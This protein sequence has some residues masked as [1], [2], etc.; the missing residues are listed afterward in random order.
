SELHAIESV[1]S[2]LE[3]NAMKIASRYIVVDD[4]RTHYLEAG[5]GPPVVLL[6][7]GEF[8]GAAELSWEFTIPALAAHYR[9][10]APDWLGFGRTDK[11]HDFTQGQARRL[12]H[13]RRF[14]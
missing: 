2:E 6:H 9:V 7:S 5:E 14:I 13:M 1:I 10:I 12:R 4:I 8:G 3:E 11:V